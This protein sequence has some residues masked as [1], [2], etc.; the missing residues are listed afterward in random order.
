MQHHRN[1]PNPPGTHAT[2]FTLTE[3]MV[4]TFCT[5]ITFAFI[6]RGLPWIG[7]LF[8]LTVIAFRTSMVDFTSVGSLAVLLTMIFGTLG[9][10][11]L[12]LWSAGW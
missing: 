3:L 2:R 10:A 8:L 6:A 7:I 1:A 5:A 9:I 4:L 11:S 12:V